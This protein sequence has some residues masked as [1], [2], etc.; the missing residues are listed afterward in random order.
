MLDRKVFF[1]EIRKS[2]G[3]FSQSQVDGFEQ[4]IG[5]WEKLYPEGDLR[6]L[7]YILA[8]AWHETART[9]QPIYERG[10]RKYFRKYEPGTRIGKRLGNTVVG[11]GYRFRGRGYV[12]L[13][14]RRNY[15]DASRRL[16]VDL[17]KE[18][19][20]ALEPEL[21]AKILIKGMMEGWFT[22]KALPQYIK[23]KADYV[24]AR[25]TV[26]GL[27]RAK[28]IA[29]YARKFSMALKKAW[30]EEPKVEPKPK[31]EDSWLVALLKRLFRRWS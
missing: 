7:G 1:D 30:K 6:M 27:D 12:Q 3:S 20:R 18:P 31:P 10:P 16:G 28:Q 13:T 5:T 4:I 2:F 23:E 19:D 15:R 11:D 26:N 17:V 24:R 8:T 9:M 29:A 14:G 22:G 21:A 25:R